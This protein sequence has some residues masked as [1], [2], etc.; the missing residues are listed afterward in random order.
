[1]PSTCIQHNLCNY[2]CWH[3]T[4]C[5]RK[6]MMANCCVA[7]IS[8]SLMSIPQFTIFTLEYFT[9]KEYNTYANAHTKGEHIFKSWN[10]CSFIVCLS[11]LFFG[12]AIDMQYA[13]DHSLWRDRYTSKI[14]HNRT[15]FE[16][17]DRMTCR[18]RSHVQLGASHFDFSIVLFCCLCSCLLFVQFLF[19]TLVC[20]FGTACPCCVP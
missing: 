14:C 11:V 15:L 6:L 1:M 10:S 2:S 3:K 8:H 18:N 5:H 19:A 12:P 13:G 7:V 16:Y 4:C 17:C 9:A 20:L